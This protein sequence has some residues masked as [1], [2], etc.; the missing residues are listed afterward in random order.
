MSLNRVSYLESWIRSPAAFR[1]HDVE[2]DNSDEAYQDLPE[3]S[4][5]SSYQSAFGPPSVSHRLNFNPYAGPGWG[6]ASA[7]GAEYDRIS[8]SSSASRHPQHRND[9]QEAPGRHFAD[10]L[11]EWTA[12]DTTGAF[13][14]TPTKRIT[15]VCIAVIYC[16]L[17]AGIVFGFA[18]LKPVLIAEGIYRQLC[19]PNSHEDVCYSQQLHLNLMFTIAAV[20]TNVAALPVGAILDTHGPRVCGVIGSLSLI[21]GT[22]LFGLA[23]RLPFDAYIPGY[24]FLSLGGPFVFISSFHLSNTFPARSGLILSLLTGAFDAS[25]AIFLLFRLINEATHGGF[26]TPTFFAIYLLVPLFILTAQ[27]SLMP[28]T[29]YKTAGELVQ[30]AQAHITADAHDRIDDSIADTDERDHRRAHRHHVISQIHDLLSDVDVDSDSDSILATTIRRPPKTQPRPHPSTTT[31]APSIPRDG[32][33]G[34]L[35]GQSALTQIRTPWFLLITLFTILQMLRINYFV[36]TLRQQYTIL[37]SSPERA[38]TLNAVFD[39][40]L[41]VG[42]LLAVPLIGTILDTT[43]MPVVLFVLVAVATLIG[44]LG[45][46]RHS[47]AAGYANVVLFVLYRP[48]YYTAVSDYA[49]KVFGFRTFGKVYGLIICLAGVGNFAQTALDALTF[50]AFARD[51]VPVNVLLTVVT[52]VVGVVLVGFV[53]SRGQTWARAGDAAGALGDEGQVEGVV[54]RDWEREPLVPG[55]GSQTVSGPYGSVAPERDQ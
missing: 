54:A 8:I 53:W 33:W 9:E 20:A 13:E 38:A 21:V 52:F 32:I 15:Q 19:P 14:V 10:K 35:H 45:C 7:E 24:L 3:D 47:L 36:A 34:V 31:T 41:P 46:I 17:S 22:L 28:A 43:S 2:S 39:I 26:T 40:L 30:Q 23:S 55:G 11:R 12:L 6:Q 51:P 18:A 50:R 48:F 25:S 27:L 49:A 37:L 44:A 42:G 16:F 1:R 4:L 29:S 5:S